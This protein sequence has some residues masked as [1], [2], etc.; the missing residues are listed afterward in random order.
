MKE[1]GMVARPRKRAYHYPGK[2]PVVYPN[3]LRAEEVE[4]LERLVVYSDIFTFTLAD[5]S[6]LYGCFAL[7]R[8]TR[9]VLSLC[10][11]YGMKSDLVSATISRIDFLD[12]ADALWH[13]DQGSQF[14]SFETLLSLVEKGFIL[15][16]S[17]AGTPTDNPFAER[18]VSTFKHAVVRR[19]PY[20]SL[21]EFLT[22][23]EDWINFYNETRPHQGINQLSPNAYARLNNL[24]TVPYLSNFTV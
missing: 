9:Q 11:D 22:A 1:Y 6:H 12:V 20:C 23:A 4:L 8:R 14:G 3:L 21:G 16:M 2:S 5:G 7:L 17:R 24:P 10:F 13:T 18:F 15:S 19:R